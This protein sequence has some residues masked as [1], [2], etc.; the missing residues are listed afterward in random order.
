MKDAVKLLAWA[1]LL[2]VSVV[3]VVWSLVVGRTAH[4]VGLGIVAIFTWVVW[5]RL[6]RWI[7]G[8]RRRVAGHLLRSAAT[9]TLLEKDVAS[10][11]LADLRRALE[12]I[13]GAEASDQ[14]GRLG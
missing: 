11:R 6:A 13:Y 10:N 3:A 7:F 14:S 9:A 4:A 2:F 12:Q 8:I 1:A 5:Y